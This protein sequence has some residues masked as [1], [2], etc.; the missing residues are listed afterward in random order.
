MIDLH[1]HIL[2]GLDD[3]AGSLED[4]LEIARA[5]VA[6]GTTVIAGTPHVRDDWP[7]DAGAME[8]RVAELAEALAQAGIP[9]EVRPGGEIALDWLSRLPIEEL[10]RFGLG[11]NPRY[12]LVETPYYGWPLALSRSLFSLRAAGI[13]PVLAHPE[14]NAE[15]HSDP[16]RLVP[17]VE[18]G[19]LV[20]V[21]A[22]SL[23]GRIGKRTQQ[24]A[25]RLVQGGLAHVIGSDAHHASVREVGM[26][27]AAKAV[28]GKLAAWLTFDVPA[29]ILAD[30]P[31]PPRP[32]GGRRAWLGKLLGS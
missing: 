1:S 9:L 29:A 12:L 5:A 17:L 2:R 24:T 19:V 4:S 15:V 14:R 26:A 27:S 8:Q 6:D 23:D 21:T 16:K 20:Q 30:E 32:A 25:R 10:Q 18:D 22:A 31:L 3:G 28:G 13:T 7:T 11:G